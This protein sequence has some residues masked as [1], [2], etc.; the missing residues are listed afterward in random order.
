MDIS[1]LNA[2]DEVYVFSREKDRYVKRPVFEDGSGKP[3]CTVP[4]A[5]YWRGPVIIRLAGEGPASGDDVV[6]AEELPAAKKR[7]AARRKAEKA[8]ETARETRHADAAGLAGELFALGVATTRYGKAEPP[9][10]D[11]YGVMVV[12]LTLEQARALRDT[13]KGQG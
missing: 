11:Y 2:G 12:S 6:T 7:H 10:V 3:Y 1:T 9:S 4:S 13:L 5:T 8:A